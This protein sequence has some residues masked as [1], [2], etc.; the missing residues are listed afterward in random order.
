MLDYKM[1]GLKIPNK[2]S[3]SKREKTENLNFFILLIL[4]SAHQGDTTIPK[5]NSQPLA[6]GL[7]EK[8]RATTLIINP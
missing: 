2:I 7:T 5:K 4:S 6:Y 1:H 8:K 3:I